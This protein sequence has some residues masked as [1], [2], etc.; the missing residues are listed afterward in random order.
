MDERRTLRVSETVRE[1]LAELI[2]FE[3]EDPRLAAVN[4]SEVHVSPDAKYARVKVAVEGD[5]R[6][7][8]QAI[9]ALEHARHY[10]RRE[11]AFRLCLRH[12]PELHFEPDRNAGADSRIDFLLRRAKRSRGEN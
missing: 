7:Q 4:V 1:E 6:G 11:L 3:L 10:L 12:V 8:N 5:E 2:A 9:A